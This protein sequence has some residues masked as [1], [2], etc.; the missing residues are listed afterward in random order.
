MEG[1]ETNAELVVRALTSYQQ[2]DDETLRELMHP[3]IE[4]YSQPGMIN[5][6][7]FT[8]F[9]G[10]KRWTAQWEE[11]WDEASYEP[12]EFIEVDDARL[13]VRVH[14]V[15]TGAGSGLKIDREYGYLY[16]I[17]DGRS[18]RFH[19]YESVQRAVEAAN[20]LAADEA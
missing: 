8:G 2:G 7:R 13:V 4:I 9:E 12:V 3:E 18:T 11:A 20:R 1:S 10:F 19:L 16:E 6:G 15:G 5:A 17:R 14:V